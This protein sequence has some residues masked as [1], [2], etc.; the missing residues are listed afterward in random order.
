[1]NLM[2]V[3]TINYFC[4]LRLIV[5][6]LMCNLFTLFLLP[7]VVEFDEGPCSTLVAVTWFLIEKFV[8]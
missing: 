1:M 6:F 2:F 8:L 3:G 5:L 7:V 4:Y